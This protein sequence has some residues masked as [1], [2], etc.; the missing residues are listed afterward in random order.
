[1]PLI[2]VK[3]DQALYSA[4][5]QLVSKGEYRDV[6]QLMEVALAN[7]LQLEERYD[8]D[9]TLQDHART[10]RSEAVVPRSMSHS[11]RKEREEPG[12][13]ATRTEAT[14]PKTN[15]VKASEPFRFSSRNDV[16][17]EPF[18]AVIRPKDELMYSLVNRLFPLKLATRWLDVRSSQLG[19]WPA[20]FDVLAPL[21]RDVEAFGSA[22]GEY[23]RTLNKRRD[24]QLA[25]SL[26]HLGNPKSIERFLTQFV[27]RTTESGEVHAGAIVQFALAAI[28]N[29]QL[30]LSRE[31]QQLS[32]LPNP[33]IDRSGNGFTES[34]TDD[35]RALLR[36]QVRQYMPAELGYVSAVLQ[37]VSG[38]SCSPNELIK[39][40][41]NVFADDKTDA[42]FRSHISGVVARAIDL[43]L[44]R[45]DWQGKHVLYSLTD[46]GREILVEPPIEI[47][48]SDATPTQTIQPL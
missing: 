5:M 16:S 22:L 34:L 45:R 40:L 29:G 9:A 31:G 41:R 37:T 17:I 35:E 25:T 43:R 2:A 19:H 48:T 8:A 32:R 24:E 33:I 30:V 27:V 38:G 36:Q 47:E 18:S 3:I 15:L 10:S 28:K 44:L 4:A 11:R 6:Q 42:S 7:H 14:R 1:M 26:P 21:G 23:D 46:A 20:V 39:R 12:F 13:A